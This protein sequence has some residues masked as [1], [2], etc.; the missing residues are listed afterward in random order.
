MVNHVSGKEAW[1]VLAAV[2]HE[3]DMAILP[4]GCPSAVP[5]ED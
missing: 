1:A 3:A 2:A 4:V 5:R